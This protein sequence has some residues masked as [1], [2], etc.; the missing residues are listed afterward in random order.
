MGNENQTGNG[1]GR[2]YHESKLPENYPIPE[3]SK[4]PI[5]FL[6]VHDQVVL[7]SQMLY[8]CYMLYSKFIEI[9]F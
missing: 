8:Y 7:I 6:L 2:V 4:I 5:K 9:Y 3:I 1:Y